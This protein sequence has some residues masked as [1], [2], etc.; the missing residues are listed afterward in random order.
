MKIKD[1]FSQ[2]DIDIKALL[3]S[4]DI[5][6]NMLQARVAKINMISVPLKELI[7]EKKATKV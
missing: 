3:V 4:G 7:E 5:Q 2:E 6:R 1:F